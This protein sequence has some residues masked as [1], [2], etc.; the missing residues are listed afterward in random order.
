LE[1][2]STSTRTNAWYS[3]DIISAQQQQQHSLHQD[4]TESKQQQQQQQQQQQRQQQQQSVLIV[5]SPFHQ[6]RSFYTFKRAAAQ[7]GL[8]IQVGSGAQVYAVLCCATN[9]SAVN[10]DARMPCSEDHCTVVLPAH[11]QHL[12]CW[13][14]ACSPA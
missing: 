11:A 7:K 1:E 4:D 10:A 5:T 6:L 3:L 14:S 12:H 9:C 13:S 8:S 2:Q